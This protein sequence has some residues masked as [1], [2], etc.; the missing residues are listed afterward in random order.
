MKCLYR[1]IHEFQ[2][3]SSP[4]SVGV[5]EWEKQLQAFHIIFEESKIIKCL[6]TIDNIY[7]IIIDSN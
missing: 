5:L 7:L 3:S 2:S 6:K 1:K 4:V